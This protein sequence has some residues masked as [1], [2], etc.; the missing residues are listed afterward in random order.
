MRHDRILAVH[1]PGIIASLIEHTDIQAE[2]IGEIDRSADRA[3]IRAD[4]HHVLGVDLEI[5]DVSKECLYK[6]I[7]GPHGLEAVEGY[8]ILY[9]GVVG[10]KGNDVVNAHIYKFL[11]CD[12]TVEGL[13]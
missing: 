2:R 7:C 1:D 5:P 9:S 8:S 11:Q 13:S 12:C 3:F 6:L 10:I 4:D